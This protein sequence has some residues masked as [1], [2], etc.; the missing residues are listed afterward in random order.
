MKIVFRV[1][2]SVTIGTGHVMRCLT[3]AGQLRQ[4]KADSFFV[5]REMEGNVIS[6]IR[7]QHFPVFTLPEVEDRRVLQWY[8]RNWERDARE[9]L[10]L[11]ERHLDSAD[12]LV[13]DH[14]GLDEKWES[15]VKPFAKKLMVIDDLANRRHDCDIL[16]DQNY[17]FRY[18]ERY[19]D[20]VPPGCRQL[21]GPGYALLREEFFRAPRRVRNG[22]IRNILV[23]FGGSDPTNETEK[24]LE[25]LVRLEDPPAVHVVVGAANPKKKRIEEICG[26]Y[27]HLFFHCQVSNLAELMNEADLAIGAGGT[28]TWE[29]LFL[30]LPALIVVVAENQRELAEAVSAFGAAVNLGWSREVTPEKIFHE[31]SRLREDPEK[32]RAMA[33]RAGELADRDMVKTYPVLKAMMGEGR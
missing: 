17:V 33:E 11:L 22:E 1:D 19:K 15:R 16:L 12:F 32:V 3:L 20:L 30:G 23:F 29:R 13:V 18:R 21:L 4:R 24:A 26:S 27:P 8:D 2:S 9:T 31:I 7:E 14:Y 5:C 6:L 10:S 28:A 25:A